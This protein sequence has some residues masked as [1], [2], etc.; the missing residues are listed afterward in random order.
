ME[1]EIKEIKGLEC[2]TT[3]LIKL[4]EELKKNPDKE[5]LEYEGKKWIKED[6]VILKSKVMKKIEEL[7]KK[8]DGTNKGFLY[9]C[10][11]D[12]LEELI[13]KKAIQS[14]SIGVN[15]TIKTKKELTGV[16]KTCLGCTR[17]EQEGF[18]GVKE[19]K[20]MISR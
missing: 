7:V 16:C 12:L 8:I 14:K 6:Y 17:L 18:L 15:M 11:V 19:C 5:W 2:D 20:Y 3:A 4:E 10:E 9:A 13:G 1:E